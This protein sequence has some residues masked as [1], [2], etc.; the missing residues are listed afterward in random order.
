MRSANIEDPEKDRD[1]AHQALR[2]MAEQEG[3]ES[4]EGDTQ[5]DVWALTSICPVLSCQF[6][7]LKSERISGV[8]V[9]MCNVRGV[10]IC[11]STLTLLCFFLDLDN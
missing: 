2:S 3:M 9:T 7:Q 11:I 5:E 4:M 6:C 1:I 10:I 8:C